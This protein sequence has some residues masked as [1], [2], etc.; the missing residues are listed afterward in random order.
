MNTFNDFWDAYDNKKSRDKCERK[1]HLMSAKD[2]L[3]CIDSLPSYIKSTPN[4]EFR[5]HPAT[6]LNQKCW[7]DT[8]YKEKKEEETQLYRFKDQRTISDYE[9]KPYDRAKGIQ[10]MRDKLKRNYENGGFIRDW[11]GIY[12]ALLTE[13]CSMVI[14]LDVDL[15]MREEV[16]IDMHRHRNRFED[17]YTGNVESDVRDKCLNHFLKECRESGRKIYEEI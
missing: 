3:A 16:T 7:Q 17:P 12:T 10:N 14:P 9:P 2:Q 8:L 1:W 5:K 4:R 13:K 6:Y 11:G 15:R